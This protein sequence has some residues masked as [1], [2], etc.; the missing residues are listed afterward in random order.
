MV[1]VEHER[2]HPREERVIAVEVT[3]TRLHHTDRRVLEVAD[4]AHQ[5]RRLRQ[6]VRVE[7]RDELALGDLE[8]IVER[9][10]L[11]AGAV[12]AVD[13]DHVEIAGRRIRR[14]LA[15]ARAHEALGLVRRVVEDLD[16]EAVA[17]VIEARDVIEDADGDRG[18]VEQR[19]LHGDVRELVRVR[20]RDVGLLDLGEALAE[21]QTCPHEVGA[22]EAVAREEEQHGEIYDAKRGLHGAGA[23]HSANLRLSLTCNSLHQTVALRQ[24][25]N[26]RGCSGDRGRWGRAPN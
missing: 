13:V 2:L 24:S 6:E 4:E 7:D 15:D 12:G 14:E 19:E 20:R 26:V 18:F 25:S 1:A 22:V 5:E 16:F 10:G 17:R 3:P 21:P 11:I 8:A 23:K 9:A